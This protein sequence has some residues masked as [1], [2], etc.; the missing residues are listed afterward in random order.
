MSALSEL[1]AG[2]P[3]TAFTDLLIKTVLAVARSHGF[4]PPDRGS[5][6]KLAAAEI[7]GEFVARK[8]TG[9]TLEALLLTCP[10]DR[11]LAAALQGVMR[12]FLRDRGRTTEMGR[13]VVRLRRALKAP[14]YQKVPPGGRYALAEGP[15][16]P[17]TVP[18][19][20]LLAATSGVRVKYLK[21]DPMSNRRPPFASKASIDELVAAVMKAAI[22]SLLVGDIAHAI[23]PALQVVPGNVLVELDEGD[24]PDTGGDIAGLDA[25]GMGIEDRDRAFEVFGLLTDRQKIALGCLDLGAR[26]LAPLIGLGHSQANVIRTAAIDRLEGELGDEENGQEIAQLVLQIAKFWVEHR[27]KSDNVTYYSK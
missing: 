24:P 4:P 5:W 16:E 9:K 7:A 25:L 1:R 13:L 10:D 18:P 21:W 11:A 6:N 12:N 3:S 19:D 15:T 20:D 17:S 23:A 2:T 27:T 8:R 14:A 22:G 26:E